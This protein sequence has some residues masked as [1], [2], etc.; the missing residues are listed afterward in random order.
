MVFSRSWKALNDDKTHFQKGAIDNYRS[1]R[2]L[3]HRMNTETYVE[4]F[5]PLDRKKDW[6]G[7][8]SI[9]ELHTGMQQ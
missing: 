4:F 6:R 9:G 7:Q 3:D 5:N 1:G 8:E 2:V